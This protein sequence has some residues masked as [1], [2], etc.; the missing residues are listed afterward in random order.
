MQKMWNPWSL[1]GGEQVCSAAIIS[2]LDIWYKSI[3]VM[4]CLCHIKVLIKHYYILSYEN[5][6]FILVFVQ[7]KFKL[8]HVRVNCIFELVMIFFPWT[9]FLFILSSACYI[10]TVINKLIGQ[11]FTDWTCSWYYS[12]HS[13]Y[14][15]S[16]LNQSSFFPKRSD[17]PGSN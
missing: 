11:S 8:I 9:N 5:W 16:E 13:F 14:R 2:P 15:G 6:S 4:I 7:I 10:F 12:E 1:G 17:S 3:I